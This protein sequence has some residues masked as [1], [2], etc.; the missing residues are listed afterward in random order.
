MSGALDIL[1]L[2]VVARDEEDNIA[3]CLGSLPGAGEAVVVVDA[4]SVDGTAEAARRLGARVYER[5]FASAAE[6]KNWGMAQA[7][8]EWIL[9]LDADETATP[10]LARSVAEAIGAPRADGYWILRRSEFLGRRIRFCGWHDD[11]ILRLFRRGAGRY[12]ERAV[13]ERLELAGE[14]AQIAGTI[15]H[16]PYRNLDE[17]VDRMKSYSRR[18]AEELRRRG[19]KWFP[20]ILLRP[21]ARFFRMYVLQ[22][23]FLDGAAGF[24]LCSLAATGVFLKYAFLRELGAED[25][26]RANGGKA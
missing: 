26:G 10:A 12:P 24:L 9:V 4:A 7:R 21:P 23:G 14:A 2:V 20:G 1:S 25:R 17:Y 11:R 16:R 22:L 19:A 8:G 15:E 13:H 5:P 3:R 18:G 6:Q